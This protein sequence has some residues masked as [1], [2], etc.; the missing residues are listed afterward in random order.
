MVW[1]SSIRC[2][3]GKMWHDDSKISKTHKRKKAS[4]S[5]P[6]VLTAYL[7]AYISMLA[8]TAALLFPATFIMENFQFA[9]VK[10][11]NR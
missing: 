11:T 8:P 1:Q 4:F 2:K 6:V 10:I 9:K 3:L 5:C 7:F